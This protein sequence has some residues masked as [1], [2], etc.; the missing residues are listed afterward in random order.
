VQII[1]TD[2]LQVALKSAY[3]QRDESLLMSL[4]NEVKLLNPLSHPSI[5]RLL[6]VV[7]HDIRSRNGVDIENVVKF[8]VYEL[9]GPSLGSLI[10]SGRIERHDRKAIFRDIVRGVQ[11]LHSKSIWHNGFLIIIT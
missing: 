10:K 4:K 6:D 11:Y 9:G 5:V 7:Y 3:D 8:V 1:L 2:G